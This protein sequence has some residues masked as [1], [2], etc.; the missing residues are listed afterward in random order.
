MNLQGENL[1]WGSSGDN[2]RQLQSAL[3][4]LGLAV[5]ATEQQSAM[6]GPGTNAAVGQFPTTHG[7]AA[8]GVIEA[9]T[10]RG[11]LT[12]GRPHHLH[13]DRHSEEPRPRRRGR[14]DYAGGGQGGRGDGSLDRQRDRES[15]TD[16]RAGVVS[17]AVST[18][19]SGAG[20]VTGT[21]EIYDRAH[22]HRPAHRRSWLRG[23]R[24]GGPNANTT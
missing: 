20:S 19:N 2:V 12:S 23:A 9:A 18:M 16:E 1:T 13:R 11:D 7:I 10:C 24:S 3:T 5:P 15:V 21:L 6:F 8:T 17:G 22:L 14:G 4:S